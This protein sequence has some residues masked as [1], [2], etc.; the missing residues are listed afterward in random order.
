[1]TDIFK[2][3]VK[4]EEE[5]RDQIKKDEEIANRETDELVKEYLKFEVKNP[6]LSKAA[7]AA[8]EK[9]ER[10]AQALKLVGDQAELLVQEAEEEL[11]R[12]IFENQ[13]RKRYAEKM[14]RNEELRIDMSS[15]VDVPAAMVPEQ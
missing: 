11:E 14:E 6:N 1:M 7:L 15:Q 3:N 8:S 13:K 9:A 12:E 10:E 5:R 4:R 2:R